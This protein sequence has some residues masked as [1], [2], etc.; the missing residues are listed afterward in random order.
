MRELVPEAR[1]SRSPTAR[2]TR[3]SSSRRMV[4]FC[5]ASPTCSCAR[6]SSSP[7]STSR[8]PTPWSSSAPTPSGWP[9]STR[10][11]AA[12]AARASAPTPTCS[13]PAAA[14]LTEEADRAAGRAVGLHRAG[15]GLQDR[16]ARP[17]DPR[18]RQPARRRAVRPRRRGRLRALHADARRGGA[19]AAGGGARRR[20]RAGAHGRNVDAYVPG[21]YVPYEEAKIEVHRRVAAPATWPS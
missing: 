1:A 16:H 7:A 3:S 14:A 17:R 18:R 2:W 19:R 9:S 4:D 21:D 11:A 10:S 13:T 5:A 15:R 8:R 6:R 20:V 12:W